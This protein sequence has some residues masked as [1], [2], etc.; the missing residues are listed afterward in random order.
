MWVMSFCQCIFQGPKLE[1]PGLLYKGPAIGS[2]HTRARWKRLEGPVKK[3]G[4]KGPLCEALS[5]PGP[6]FQICR[7][8]VAPHSPSSSQFASE[9]EPIP[10]IILMFSCHQVRKDDAMAKHA[11][12]ISMS[13]KLTFPR[14]QMMT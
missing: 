3:E 7:A 11:T 13:I 9:K 8:G 1:R 5:R 14:L 4:L 2:K 6:L 10:Q 12:I